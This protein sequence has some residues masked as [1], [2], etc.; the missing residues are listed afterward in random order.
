M[1]SVDSHSG[2]HRTKATIPE[3]EA[4]AMIRARGERIATMGH[5][6]LPW[7]MERDGRNR[8]WVV[9]KRGIRVQFNPGNVKLILRALAAYS[10]E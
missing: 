8:V 1:R 6:P 4:E 9:D 10:G 3:A 5:S 7:H 2:F